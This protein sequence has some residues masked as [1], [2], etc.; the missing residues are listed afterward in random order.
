[1]KKIYFDLDRLRL[2]VWPCELHAG[3][4]RL[5]T[6]SQNMLHL[7]L[8]HSNSGCTNAPMCHAV[9]KLPAFLLL[10]QVTLQIA[11]CKT[12][13]CTRYN[14]RNI[15]TTLKLL[16][17]ISLSFESI[18]TAAIAE[19]SKLQQYRFPYQGIVIP[20]EGSYLLRV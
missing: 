19:E 17:H 6:H 13:I 7:L 1:V 4:V 11:G 2:P 18:R 15:S 3:C 14:I 9:G 12:E 16:L 10:K 8:F 5:Q 20:Q